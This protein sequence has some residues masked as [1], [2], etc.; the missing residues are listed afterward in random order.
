MTTVERSEIKEELKKKVSVTSSKE[1]TR[2]NG[3]ID[4][5]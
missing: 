2:M 5:L 1:K 3:L 4:L